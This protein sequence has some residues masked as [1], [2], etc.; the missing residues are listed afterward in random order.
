MD[1]TAAIAVI[2][3][4][5]RA[6]AVIC[7][8]ILL[9]AVVRPLL[10][11]SPEQE[12]DAG[13][14][15]QAIEKAKQPPADYSLPQDRYDKAVA[16]ARTEYALYFI[17]TVW[18]IL[19]LVLLLHLGI[20][21]R[22]RDLA[23]RV[24]NRRYVQSLIFVPG[25]ILLLGALHLPV[26]LYA[27]R[28]VLQ[29][30]LSVQGWGSWFRDWAK[31]ELLTIALAFLV[32]W[33][34]FAAM[35]WKPQTWWLYFWIAIIPV[36]LFIFFIS[37]WFLDP[38]FN[39]FQPL[40]E[41][42]PELVESIGKLTQRAGIPIPAERMFLME[43]SAKST[44]INAYV[45]GIGASKRV[46]VWDTTIQK[47]SPEEV[48]SIV[49]HEI[50]HYVLG[51][52]WKGFLFFVVGMFFGLYL[53]YRLLQWILGRWGKN[54]GVRGQEDWAA[55]AVL[56]LIMRVLEFVGLPIGNGFSRMQEH[57][58]DVYGL[59]VTHGLIPDS[60]EVA[61]RAFQ[62]L[63]NVDLSDPNPSRFITFWLFDHPPLTDRLNFARSYDPWSRGQSPQFVK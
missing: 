44:E 59:E 52:I 43:A 33:I 54:W 22:L 26:S 20:V 41:K 58:A 40:Q 62:V 61:A 11:A 14:G 49:G 23:E 24:G 10:A 36:A 37:P 42:H 5:C 63:G 56:L 35:R 9:I 39:K 1:S 57:Q 53:A 17:S 60:S 19:C 3:R 21:A 27:H 31:G 55:L 48:L 15:S 25:L 8:L 45:T 12:G 30:E 7:I 6:L 13:A 28:L 18:G 16:L 2:R 32:V 29:Y 51:H 47:A 4:I 38:L 50:G 46:V 34:L